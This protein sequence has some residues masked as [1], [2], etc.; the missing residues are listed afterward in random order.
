MLCR[1][2]NIYNS[3]RD[4]VD[5]ATFRLTAKEIALVK[6]PVKTTEEIKGKFIAAASTTIQCNIKRV[7]VQEEHPSY[8][9]EDSIET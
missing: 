8:E 1:R 9:A 4:V 2:F 3:S 7:M 6:V 5:V